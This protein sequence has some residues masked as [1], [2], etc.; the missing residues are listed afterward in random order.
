MASVSVH[1]ELVSINNQDI[2]NYISVNDCDIYHY[3]NFCY[4][5]NKNGFCV[6]MYHLPDWFGKKR[7]YDGK[8][9]IRNIKTYAK[10]NCIVYDKYLAFFA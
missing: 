1:K 2:S 5:V 8:K 9:S 6:T 4:I 7:Y 3:N 10:N